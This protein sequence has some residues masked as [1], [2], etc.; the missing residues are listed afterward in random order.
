MSG[1]VNTV[2]L[3]SIILA[4][5]SATRKRSRLLPVVLSAVLGLAAFMFARGRKVWAN[6][7][8]FP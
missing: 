6:V 1:T 8:P 2:N 7:L 3:K 5:R 4:G